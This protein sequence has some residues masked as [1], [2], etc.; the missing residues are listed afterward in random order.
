MR[1]ESALREVFTKRIAEFKK[2]PFY[3][4][5]DVKE[6][7]AMFLPPKERTKVW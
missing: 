6:G 2:V 5:F 3:Q 4:T 1:T 7:D